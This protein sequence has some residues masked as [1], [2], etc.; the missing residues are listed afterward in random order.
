MRKKF[1]GAIIQE[2]ETLNASA[3]APVCGI[4]GILGTKTRTK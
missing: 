2:T 1:P 4:Q 3:M